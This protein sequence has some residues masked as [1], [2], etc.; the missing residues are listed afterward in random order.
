M[1]WHCQHTAVGQQ[2]SNCSIQ[3]FSTC[4]CLGREFGD[5]KP[6]PFQPE[7]WNKEANGHDW[8][9]LLI[10]QQCVFARRSRWA[11]GS[12]HPVTPKNLNSGREIQSLLRRRSSC[13]TAD[14]SKHA[15]VCANTSSARL[16]PHRQ[17]PIWFR[18]GDAFAA[19]LDTRQRKPKLFLVVSGPRS[20]EGR[21]RTGARAGPR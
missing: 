9:L 15:V 14:V 11:A 19:R 16:R 17:R 5:E 8:Y 13:K 2:P 7:M 21:Q 12:T 18:L 4:H 1:R 10:T 20:L 6:K 3:S